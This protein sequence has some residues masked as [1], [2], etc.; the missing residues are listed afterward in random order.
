VDDGDLE[1]HQDDGCAAGDQELAAAAP[2]GGQH[3]GGLS[4]LYWAKPEAV[5]E[6]FET[7]A[8]QQL[9]PPHSS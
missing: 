1:Q 5:R 6:M 9:R 3:A 7:P 2:G 4:I 8:G